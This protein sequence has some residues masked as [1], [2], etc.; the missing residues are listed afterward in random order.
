MVDTSEKHHDSP[1]RRFRARFDV[2]RDRGRDS[3]AHLP[4]GDPLET[5]RL[6]GIVARNVL[7]NLS[8][9]VILCR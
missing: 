7:P 3:R 5:A 8:R 9:Y 4:K 6:A 1:G 2:R